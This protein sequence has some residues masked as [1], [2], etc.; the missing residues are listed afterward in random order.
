MIRVRDLNGEQLRNMARFVL[1]ADQEQKSERQILLNLQIS[2]EDLDF[3][4]K[5]ND[6]TDHPPLPQTLAEA[7]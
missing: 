7:A 6:R 2:K 3:L 4:R 5:F 1:V